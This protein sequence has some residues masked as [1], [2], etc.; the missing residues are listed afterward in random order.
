MDRTYVGTDKTDKNRQKHKQKQTKKP[1][2]QIVKHVVFVCFVLQFVY[3]H[4]QKYTAYRSLRVRIGSCLVV[5]IFQLAWLTGLLGV[6]SMADQGIEMFLPRQYGA[7][8]NRITGQQTHGL[9]NN[10]SK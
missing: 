4:I 3:V 1:Q 7:F 6:H 5:T 9:Y 10:T 2:N 8:N